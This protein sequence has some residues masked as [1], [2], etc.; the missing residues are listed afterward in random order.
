[1]LGCHKKVVQHI[2]TGRVATGSPPGHGVLLFRLYF[3]NV[4]D[5]VATAPGSDK[6]CAEW[7]IFL[8]VQS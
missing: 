5:P 3:H 8:S 7:F 4:E 6:L 1:M 2:R